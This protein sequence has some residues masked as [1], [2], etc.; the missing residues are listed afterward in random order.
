MADY[1][2]KLREMRETIDQSDSG[3]TRSDETKARLNNLDNRISKSEYAGAGR[4]GQ[5]G[6]TAKQADQNRS[7]MSASEK[8]ARDGADEMK[9]QERTNKAAEAASKN[10]KKG[11][12]VGSASRRADG[13]AQRGKTKGVMVMCGGGMARGRK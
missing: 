4:G 11:G 3:M 12:S 7:I 13:I 8:A 1:S 6:P 2:K 10:M 5:G 9:L